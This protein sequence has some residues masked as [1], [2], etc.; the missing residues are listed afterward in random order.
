[1]ITHRRPIR[2]AALALTSAL[3]L[4]SCSTQPDSGADSF[5]SGPASSEETIT[6]EMAAVLSPMTDVVNAAA[7][8]I[9]DGYEIE[10]VEV[11]DYVTANVVLNDGDIYGNF[12]QHEPYMEGFNAG[13]D[14]SLVAVQPVYN[15]V[16]AFYSQTIED[17]ADLP[18]GGTVAIP[19]DAS[20][21]GRALNLL[22]EEGIITLDPEIDPYAATVEDVT[23]NPKELEFLEVAIPAL[24][25]AYEEADLVFQWPSQIAALGLS[26]EE[27]GL[28]TELDDDFALQV[29]VRGED[30]DSPATEALKE[31]FTSEAVRDVIDSNETIEI[32]FQE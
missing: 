17:I 30:A 13:N 26:P 32:A 27:D 3:M 25:A 10:L 31:A 11:S 15:F 8:A 2:L 5:D 19:D 9:D 7:E 22:A 18:T 4:T 28:L 29:V 12:S 21:R 16:I 14:A 1:M 20:N 6:L 24:N 23:E